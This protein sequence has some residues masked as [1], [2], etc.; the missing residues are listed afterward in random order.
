[1]AQPNSDW[2]IIHPRGGRVVLFDALGTKAHVTARFIGAPT[3]KFEE[4]DLAAHQTYLMASNEAR[5]VEVHSDLP[6]VASND[7]P[8]SVAASQ[9]K[10]SDVLALAASKPA[11]ELYNP[12]SGPA[13]V[14]L[15]LI[16]SSGERVVV[17]TVAP[18]HVW[19][20]QLKSLGGAGAGVVLASDVPVAAAP[21]G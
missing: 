7:S 12:G 10:T 1:M 19:V 5:T 18:N 16:T 14:S 6:M 11:V 2:Y 13:H 4:V 15:D 20:P 3:V 9:A 17:K 21:A 8:N